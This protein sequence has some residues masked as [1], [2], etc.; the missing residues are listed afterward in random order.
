MLDLHPPHIQTKINCFKKMKNR[1]YTR[2]EYL[3][4]SIYIIEII[5]WAGYYL[6]IFQSNIMRNFGFPFVFV[7][8]YSIT[9][10]R[11]LFRSIEIVE[12]S[13]RIF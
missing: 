13:V 3:D 7:F 12:Y 1:Y 2:K 5:G 4:S 10:I 11:I 6:I 8:N 9:H